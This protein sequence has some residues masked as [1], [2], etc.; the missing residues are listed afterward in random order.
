MAEDQNFEHEDEFAAAF[1]ARVSQEVGDDE[2]DDD[3]DHDAGQDDAGQDDGGQDDGGQDDGGQDDGGQDDG[4]EP[5]DADHRYESLKGRHQQ[6]Q[7]ENRLLKERLQ[8]LERKDEPPKPE[9]MAEADVPEELRDDLAVISGLDPELAGLVL[10]QSADGERLRKS[11]AKFGPETAAALADSLR[12]RRIVEER[13]H[14]E[15]VVRKDR[16]AVK[17]YEEILTARPELDELATMARD[18]QGQVQLAARKGKEA[19]FNAY[20]KGLGEWLD[21]LPH[22]TARVYSDIVWRTGNAKEVADVLEEY[23]KARTAREHVDTDQAEELAP[24]R[25]RSRGPSGE[26]PA[27]DPNTFEGAFQRRVQSER[28]R[29]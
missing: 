14:Q 25:T 20:F 7:E 12:T 11:L 10:E 22:K 28:K 8:Q 24:V 27:A 1:A 18:A 3:H 19:E 2:H 23:G 29:A 17:Q 16:A 5:K 4:A 6:I 26:G 13:H 21:E 9:Q 15:E